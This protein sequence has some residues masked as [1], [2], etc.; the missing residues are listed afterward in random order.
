MALS[1]GGVSQ[2]QVGL[3]IENNTVY[4][5]LS[6]ISL[7]GQSGLVPLLSIA[8][9]RLPL[10]DKESE[11]LGAVPSNM[12]ALSLYS[13]QLY[14]KTGHFQA[15]DVFPT[16]DVQPQKDAEPLMSSNGWAPEMP[17]VGQ[18]WV[19]VTNEGQGF[20]IHGLQDN[21]TGGQTHWVMD[22]KGKLST[23]TSED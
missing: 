14:A 23:L 4:S 10:S 17:L 9:Q 18:Y 13:H 12:Q 5:A 2:V 16:S 22:E 6:A 7:N 21:G 3:S 1:L 15:M 11:P 8:G 19:E 20:M